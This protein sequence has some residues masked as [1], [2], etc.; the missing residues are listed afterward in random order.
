M[1]RK[2]NI[3]QKHWN[4]VTSLQKIIFRAMKAIYH[5]VA[6]VFSRRVK[7]LRPI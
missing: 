1:M 6:H 3:F 2:L 4:F 5:V 7:D